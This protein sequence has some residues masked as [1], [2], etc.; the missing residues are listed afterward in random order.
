MRIGIFGGTFNPVHIGHL[1]AAQSAW[2]KLKLDRVIFVPSYL[3]PHKSS[4]NVVA[5]KDRFNMVSAA[6]KGNLGF[7]VLDFE[8]KSKTRSYSIETVNYLIKQYPKKTKFF[9]IG[10]EDSLA[11]L[12][13]WKCIEELLTKVIFA[14]VYRPGYKKFSSKIKVQSIPMPGLDISS[15]EIR[16]RINQGKSV[17]YFLPE[18]VLRYIEKKKLYLRS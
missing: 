4:K 8:I 13:S 6:I 15:S 7:K 5:A 10:G 3:P 12:S 18:G 14:M 2:E 11:T 17:R 1:I 16:K 9:F